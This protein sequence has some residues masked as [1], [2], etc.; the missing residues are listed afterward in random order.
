[1]N[2]ASNPWSF[3]PADVLT[4]IPV[5][6]PNGLVLNA[7]KTVTLTTTGAHGF[8]VNNGLTEINATN[9]LYNGYYVVKAVPS[10]TTAILIPQFNIPVGTAGSGGGTIAFCQYNANVR[11]EDI[12]WQKVAAAGQLLD[13][14]DRNG[15][16]IWQATAVGPGVQNRGKIFWVSGI[17]LI[18]IDSGV[19]LVTVN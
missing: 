2:I 4:A 10:P 7:D 12:S 17:T 19:V 9:P 18:E 11:V 13:M 3:F 6:S 1:V 14:R 5:A 16:I 15:N 8:V